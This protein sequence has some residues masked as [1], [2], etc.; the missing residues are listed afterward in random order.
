[1][2]LKNIVSHMCV[3]S[4]ATLSTTGCTKS[5]DTVNGDTTNNITNTVPSTSAQFDTTSG[6]LN[7][8]AWQI[9]RFGLS[10]HN[11]STA[12]T[13]TLDAN[14]GSAA[15]PGGIDAGI[16]R[17]GART[18]VSMGT[19]SYTPILTYNGPFNDFA[20]VQ[21]QITA[22]LGSPTSQR[23]L[24]LSTDH[25]VYNRGLYNSNWSLYFP[26][27]VQV[28]TTWQSDLISNASTGRVFAYH[29]V[30]NVAYRP[31]IRSAAGTTPVG[32]DPQIVTIRVPVT[33]GNVATNDLSTAAIDYLTGPGYAGTWID[34]Q[35]VGN[36][37]VTALNQTTPDA[38]F[39]DCIQV[40]LTYDFRLAGEATPGSTLL[41]LNDYA[42]NYTLYWKPG[43]G[44]VYWTGVEATPQWGLSQLNAPTDSNP[45]RTFDLRSYNINYDAGQSQIYQS[46]WGAGYNAAYRDASNDP[47][48]YY[49]PINR[50]PLGP[51]LSNYQASN[52]VSDQQ[53]LLDSS[54][55]S[56]G[57]RAPSDLAFTA[58]YNLGV[59]N[60][61]QD[62]TEIANAQDTSNNLYHGSL[63]LDANS[64]PSQFRR[65]GIW[66]LNDFGIND[67]LASP[68]PTGYSYA[69]GFD[70]LG[71]TVDAYDSTVTSDTNHIKL[72]KDAA[73]LDMR[74]VYISL[75]IRGT[76]TTKTII[77]TT[78]QSGL[79]NGGNG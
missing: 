41:G 6:N 4:V 37:R 22:F 8:N 19:I 44:W 69:N 42:A 55:A 25:T 56:A 46:A 5:G 54:G 50:S 77:G 9:P 18:D 13:W 24:A 63:N 17:S 59:I 75:P 3:L 64:V 73:G 20:A 53:L 30:G 38:L 10:Y 34:L 62:F 72:K 71:E 76:I 60:Y 67:I 12:T 61:A 23:Y 43:I 57:R 16:L 39:S 36:L 14:V 70:G 74:G 40:S 35:R 66:W 32:S 58:G 11:E 7:S 45:T 78:T 15:R 65:D 2:R 68:T 33:T 47:T 49:Y 26:T 21:E 27:S 1:M 51:A 48:Y 29:S 28:G 31:R 79:T 52:G